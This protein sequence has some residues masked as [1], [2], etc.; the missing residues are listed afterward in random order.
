MTEQYSRVL[1]TSCSAGQSFL[2]EFRNRS[3]SLSMVRLHRFEGQ[4]LM[5][6]PLAL[7][8]T[9]AVALLGKSHILCC[10]FQLHSR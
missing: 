9:T 7:G 5:W 2:Q 4:N 8:Q 3:R 1:V 6:L 10:K